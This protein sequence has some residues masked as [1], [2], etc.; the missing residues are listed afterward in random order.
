MGFNNIWQV[1]CAIIEPFWPE[2]LISLLKELLSK[3]FFYSTFFVVVCHYNKLTK[4]DSLYIYYVCILFFRLLEVSRRL[5]YNRQNNL[6]VLQ[7]LNSTC[8]HGRM[9]GSFYVES[10]LADYL[11]LSIH[12]EAFEKK[13][14]WKEEREDWGQ[15]SSL[16]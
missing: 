13:W 10:V 11:S 9:Q 3:T 5:S 2:A 8:K 7:D 12:R 14:I 1:H 15:M 6:L 4:I 16:R